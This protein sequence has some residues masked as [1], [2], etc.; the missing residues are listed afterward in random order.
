MWVNKIL[1]K[2]ELSRE[3]INKIRGENLPGNSERKIKVWS[4]N[5]GGKNQNYGENKI[6]GNNQNVGE[7]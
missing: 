7:K 3:K 2:N 1:R 5:F 6:L 4:P